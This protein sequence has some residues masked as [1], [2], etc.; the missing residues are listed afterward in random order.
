[1]RKVFRSLRPFRKPDGISDDVWIWYLAYGEHGRFWRLF[2][3]KT[4]CVTLFMTFGVN[5]ILNETLNMFLFNPHNHSFRVSFTTVG[6]GVC[7]IVLGLIVVFVID[8]IEEFNRL[9]ELDR[10]HQRHK[11]EKRE[12]KRVVEQLE[13]RMN[14]D[15]VSRD[16]LDAYIDERINSND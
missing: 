3:V 2:G 8:K 14:S 12:E 13:H 11:Y 4:V 7:C 5:L 1:M 15:Y 9:R 16:E 10:E 6:I